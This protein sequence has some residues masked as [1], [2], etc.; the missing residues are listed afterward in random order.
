[1]GGWIFLS[2]L[3][4]FSALY[5]SWTRFQRNDHSSRTFGME[6]EL[7]VW[8]GVSLRT[9]LKYFEGSTFLCKDGS[10]RVPKARLNDNFCDCVDGTDEPGKGTCHFLQSNRNE[11]LLDIA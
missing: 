4:F 9:D 8:P 7:H 6:T 5:E 10:K 3:M 2:T 11:Q 1:M